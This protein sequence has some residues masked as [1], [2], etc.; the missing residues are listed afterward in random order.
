MTENPWFLDRE[1]VDQLVRDTIR[2]LQRDDHEGD[3]EGLFDHISTAT[4][5]LAKQFVA[6]TILNKVED[7]IR[8][9]KARGMI[10][11]N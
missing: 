11:N 2:F 5:K 8:F 3:N 6:E 7:T 10:A 4:R 9:N 1:V